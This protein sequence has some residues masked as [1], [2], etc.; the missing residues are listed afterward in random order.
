MEINLGYNAEISVITNSRGETSIK[1]E[2]HKSL[3]D[4]LV[5]S[6][7][8]GYGVEPFARSVNRDELLAIIKEYNELYVDENGLIITKEDL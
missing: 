6:V 8:C 5:S 2:D 7:L 3:A 4:T 1:I